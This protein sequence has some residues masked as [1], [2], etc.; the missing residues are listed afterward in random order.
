MN[1]MKGV[2]HLISQQWTK[3]K[4]KSQN[5]NNPAKLITILEEIDDL[6][7]T[8]EMRIAS[9]QNA[10]SRENAALRTSNKTS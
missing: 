3:L 9:D 1:N 8:L 4:R 10:P 6:L 7:S 2:E 5:E